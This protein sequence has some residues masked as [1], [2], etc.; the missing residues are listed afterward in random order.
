MLS[1]N[2]FWFFGIRCKVVEWIKYDAKLLGFIPAVLVFIGAYILWFMGQKNKAI[3]TISNVHSSNWYASE[4]LT[5]LFIILTLKRGDGVKSKVKSIGG[6][7]LS[8][9]QLDQKKSKFLAD[10]T[11]LFVHMLIVIRKR[12]EGQ[13]GIIILKYSYYFPLMF[14]FF[15][16]EKLTQN[17]HLVLEPSWAGYMDMS[18]L[19]YLSLDEPIFVMTYE[20]KDR[21]LLECLGENLVPVDIGPN[22]WVDY[23]KFAPVDGDKDVDV[24]IMASW[25]TF[26]RHYFIF[27][28][29]KNVLLT[30]PKLKI[31]LAGYQGDL[32][33][34]FILKLIEYFELKDNVEVFERVPS[35]EVAKLL[36]RSKVNIL[37]SRFEGNNRS[38]IEGFFCNTP[39]ILR[40][41]HNFG[42]HYPYINAQTGTFSNEASLAKNI[43][44]I[45]DGEQKY[46]PREYVMEKHNYKCA[47]QEIINA[48]AQCEPPLVEDC[49]TEYKVNLLK[50]MEYASC[51]ADKYQNDY[52]FLKSLIQK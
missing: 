52:D 40:E 19:L 43:I 9:L 18:I 33:K 24:M 48:I 31:V 23:E 26:K 30:K 50:G 46:S 34:E 27:K 16:M 41:G 10:P 22:W 35:E 38:I 36:A 20:E 25:S 6:N 39:A 47:T 44:E 17:Y 7:Y 37:W 42:F 11:L 13:K 15:D 28:A 32:G 45:V 14:K 4:F 5:K 1:S 12:K 29:L 49:L 21:H 3:T 2:K 51:K 8:N